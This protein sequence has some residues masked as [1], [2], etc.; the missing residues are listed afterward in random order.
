[1]AVGHSLLAMDCGPFVLD[2]ILN[3]AKDLLFAST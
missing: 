3:E 1:M 2:V